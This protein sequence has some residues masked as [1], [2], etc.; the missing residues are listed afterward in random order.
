M[1]SDYKQNKRDINAILGFEESTDTQ[2]SNHPLSKEEKMKR[3][4]AAQNINRGH[5]R[6]GEQREP[7]KQINI[8]CPISSSEELDSI[9]FKTGKTK[10]SLMEEAIKHLARKYVRD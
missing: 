4:R 1:N 10:R 7:M 5:P 9:S 3:L 8:T 6:K 2:E